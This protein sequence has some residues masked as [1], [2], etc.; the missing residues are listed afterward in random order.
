MTASETPGN[1]VPHSAPGQPGAPAAGPTTEPASVVVTVQITMGEGE[2]PPDAAELLASIRALTSSATIRTDPAPVT[3][4]VPRPTLVN[5]HGRWSAG[6]APGAGP[7]AGSRAADP[8]GPGVVVHPASRAV[9][10]DGTPV[11]L[12]RR[13]FDLLLFFCEHPYQ[14]FGRGQLLRQ[15]WG[16]EPLGGDRTVDVHV[17]RVRTKLGVRTPVISTVRGVGYRLAEHAQVSVRRD[18]G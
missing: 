11:E 9:W 1:A 7:P 3:H 17:R 12:T 10:C 15:V 2:L 14:V 4:P 16:Y 6:T 5:G 8:A 13:E 18:R